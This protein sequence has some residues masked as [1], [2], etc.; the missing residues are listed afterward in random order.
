V[1]ITVSALDI[2]PIKSC[3]R[4]S[5]TSCAIAATGLENDRLF[6]LVTD[7][8]TC[9]T[10]RQHSVLATVSPQV[11]SSGL[12]VSAPGASTIAI[13]RP[14]ELDTTVKA[15]LGDEVRVADAGDE[16][17]EWFSSIVGASVRLVGMTPDSDRQIG[18]PQ[19]VSFA[20]AGPILVA[21][22]AS[23]TYLVERASE[24][25][26]MDRFRPN[27]VVAGAAAWVEDSWQS[28]TIGGSTLA[29]MMAWPRCA[30]PQIDQVTAE[31][32]R[33]PAKVLRSHRWCSSVPDAPG[34]VRRAVEGNAL[35][36]VTFTSLDEGAVI[37]VGDEVEVAVTAAPLIPAPP[38]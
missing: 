13:A 28:I 18:Q 19:A 23:L 32:H 10:Q 14:R 11:T 30:I 15:L 27:I 26:G 12:S 16:A 29:H 5:L 1:S 36:G 38:N 6:Q 25:F 20:D 8:G 31:R 4:V 3:Q 34:H 24:S 9:V 37:S 35:F 33:E 2:Y 22:D 21:N 17:A 7:E